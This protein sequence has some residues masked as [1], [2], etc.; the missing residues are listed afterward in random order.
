MNSRPLQTR[1]PASSDHPHLQ[2][3]TKDTGF[4]PSVQRQ[5]AEEFQLYHW[6]QLQIFIHP[7]TPPVKSYLW[8]F[9][10]P[11]I[12]TEVNLSAVFCRFSR[13]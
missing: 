8:I 10:T 7:L 6:L 11:L 9:E 3:A 1:G 12:A 2:P 5:T 4:V 13:K